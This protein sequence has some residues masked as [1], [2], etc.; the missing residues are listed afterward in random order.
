MSL[1]TPLLLEVGVE[2]TVT[3]EDDTLNARPRCVVVVF[4]G[5]YFLFTATL[6]GFF[7]SIEQALG[8][9]AC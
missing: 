5:P 9:G 3:A 8:V 4:A 1:N 7:K 2:S 6:F